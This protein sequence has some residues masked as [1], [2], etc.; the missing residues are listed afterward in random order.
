MLIDP[1]T[2][3]VSIGKVTVLGCT[4]FVWRVNDFGALTV[5]ENRAL[6]AALFGSMPR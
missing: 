3:E 5:L 1:A 6:D 2:G 4:A